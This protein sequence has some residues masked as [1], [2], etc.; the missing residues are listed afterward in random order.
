MNPSGSASQSPQE[1]HLVAYVDKVCDQF[2]AAWQAK[3]SDGPRPRIEDFLG[4]LAEPGRSMLVRELL[5]LELAYRRDAGE[6]PALKEYQ[7]RFPEYATLFSTWSWKPFAP[8][9]A[10]SGATQ[11]PGPSIP[12]YQI[13]EELGRGGMGVVYKARQIG[14][15]RPVALKMILAGELA[16]EE[17]LARFR[18]EAEAVARLQHPHIVQIHEIGE[19]S[20]GPY[21]SLEYVEGG[22]LDKKIN[23]TPL[24][25]HQ[26]ARLVETLARAMHAAHEQGI[27]HRDLKPQNVM[28][29]AAGE[30]KI[31]DFGLAKKLD[32]AKGRTRSGAIVGTPS[33]MAPE[34]AGGQ[35]K[36]IGPAADI[37]AMGAIL[38]ELLTGRPPFRAETP[39]DTVLQ[40]LSEE[41]IPPTKLN[42]KVPRDLE[43]ICLK[44]LRKEPR[45]RYATAEDLAEDVRRFQAKEPISARATPA[46]ERTL[47][48]VRRRPAAAILILV[49]VLALGGSTAAAM[50][51]IGQLRDFNA[52]LEAAAQREKRKADEA[53][54]QSGLAKKREA[55]ARRERIKAEQLATAEK[56]AR[57]KEL[58]AREKAE[59]ALA[60]SET[61]VAQSQWN[62]GNVFLAHQVLAKVRPRYRFGGWRYLNR[63]FEGS[64]ATLRGHTRPIT[65][66][67]FSPDGLLLASASLD[68]E[69]KIW[70][71]RTG[72]ELHTVP[73]SGVVSF[74]PAGRLLAVPDLHGIKLCN[75]HTGKQ[76]R[77]IR[78]IGDTAIFSPDGQMLFSMDLFSPSRTVGLKAGIIAEV[79][80]GQAVLS[81]GLGSTYRFGCAAFSPDGLLLASGSSNSLQNMDMG[82]GDNT[83]RLWSTTRSG[84]HLL[85]IL[86]GHNRMVQSVAFS[87]DGRLIASASGNRVM[88]WDARNGA[89]IRTLRD[90]GN[91]VAFRPD[92]LLLAL[93]SGEGTI[94]LFDPYTGEKVR[95]LRG[96]TDKITCLCFSP[97]GMFLASGSMDATVKL[98]E[99]RPRP[100]VA[101]LPGHSGGVSGVAFSPDGRLMA[102]ASGDLSRVY[103][104]PEG[105]K[106][107]RFEPVSPSGDIKPGHVV[108]WDTETGRKARTLPGHTQS[109]T[110]VTFSYDGLLLASASRDGALKVWNPRTGEEVR[111]M[112]GHSGGVAAVAFAPKSLLFAS[113]GVD[114]TIKL[115]NASNGQEV[116]TLRG[117]AGTVLSVA[118]S[119]DGRRLASASSDDTVRLWDIRTGRELLTLWDWKNHHVAFSPDGLL[120][121]SPSGITVQVLDGQ[122]GKVVRS[123][124]GHTR[125]VSSVAF[126]PDGLLASG[127]QDGI[128]KL[129]DAH[130]GQELRSVRGHEVVNY[131]YGVHSVAFSPAGLLASAGADGTVKLWHARTAVVANRGQP[132]EDEQRFRQLVAQPDPV[133]HEQQIQRHEEGNLFAAAFHLA[134]L[135]EIRPDDSRV[136][137]HL[138]KVQATLAKDQKDQYRLACQQWARRFAAQT[139]KQGRIGLAQAL[140]RTCTLAKD[141]GVDGKSLVEIAAEAVRDNPENP[142]YRE[143]LGAALYRAGQ[144][145]QAMN[146]MTKAV[147][148]SGQKKA[149][150]WAGFFLAMANQKLG[151]SDKAKGLF[152]R[153]RIADRSAVLDGLRYE[154]ALEL[155]LEKSA[156]YWFQQGS[157]QAKLGHWDQAVAAASKAI[158]REPGLGLYWNFRGVCYYR[159]GQWEMAVA[160]FSKAIERNPKDPA[161]WTNRGDTLAQLRQW[162]KAIGEFSKA[163]QLNPNYEL[164]WH[165][166]G[167]AHASLGQWDKAS[168]DFAK[169]AGFQKGPLSAWSDYALARLQLKDDHGYRQAC[170]RLVKE[171][172]N[173]KDR[174]TLAF[175]VWTCCLAPDARVDLERVV[176]ALEKTKQERASEE[177]YPYLRALGAALYRAGKFEP[178][179]KRLDEAIGSRKQPAP[180]TWFFLAMAHHRLGN[181]DKAKKWFEK[182]NTLIQQL[183]QKK[184]DVN[185]DNLVSWESLPW[186]ERLILDLLHRE[187]RALLK[188]SQ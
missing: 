100:E 173:I 112:R 148:L 3:G 119:P 122:T 60:H 48:W 34:Q 183:R 176:Q 82:T 77:T 17:E 39:L 118:F 141:S 59:E 28:L 120:L 156:A 174:N 90:Q 88:I 179:V 9:A 144:Y 111:T 89:Q 7:G 14:L 115:W 93:G 127:S 165:L 121:A 52:E 101:I 38:Y 128:V 147:E 91:Q 57:A 175:I 130:T 132:S 186:N 79:R 124:P 29:T 19:A 94:E 136:R 24:P 11:P 167:T 123:L 140:V 109:V 26:A 159:K 74:S 149:I 35:A 49:I 22:S 131:R 55:D 114:R 76:V 95:M 46:W 33:Y 65:S 160:D 143:T 157:A 75:A 184:S 69:A 5:R 137:E 106:R 63:Q 85:R 177:A 45:R 12:G 15:N 40:V 92:G 78:V 116:R 37:Y 50:W 64:Y 104:D 180:S 27:I 139:R 107:P 51:Y 81:L 10:S 187:A 30:P 142:L 86:N 13:L 117:H 188:N 42:A 155:G 56:A 150:P 99:V 96:H 152:E 2:E 138:L 8:S 154:A 126:S 158:D 125:G 58:K 54:Y 182:A 166:R 161:L 67:N 25:G 83:V 171:G 151:Q 129:W 134:R 185:P 110:S 172:G 178:A 68:R 84:G 103:F 21:F 181:K 97:D 168:D 98:W 43:T 23:G 16:G 62:Q 6:S 66:V 32:G 163:I 87:P 18:L 105:Q 164:A 108:L 135:V 47:K 61:M 71:V 1:L 146:E 133:W 44:C 73:G 80:T 20:T 70:N 153:Q 170:A 145:T 53:N 4:D 169:A 102:S 72:Q 113:A 162:D 36:E 41:P 31:T